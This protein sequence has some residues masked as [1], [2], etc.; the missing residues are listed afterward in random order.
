M[1]IFQ[2]NI[3]NTVT[4]K[5]MNCVNTEILDFPLPTPRNLACFFPLYALLVLHNVIC[6]GQL[7][8]NQ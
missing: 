7:C 5:S 8:Q 4:C 6:Q 1:G 3:F 2:K